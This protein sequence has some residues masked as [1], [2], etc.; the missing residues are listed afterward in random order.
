MHQH[1]H[2]TWHFT[3]TLPDQL[4]LNGSIKKSGRF[5]MT[6]KV[7][8][9][10]GGSSCQPPTARLAERYPRVGWVLKIATMI[11][12]WSDGSRKLFY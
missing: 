2:V 11:S 6:S 1:S 5:C 4:M 3:N 9:A 7:G 8:K 12:V 10:A